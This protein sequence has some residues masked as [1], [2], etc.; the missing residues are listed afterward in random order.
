MATCRELEIVREWKTVGMKIELWMT[1]ENL[2][3]EWVICGNGFCEKMA[4]KLGICG[5]H[6]EFWE[7]R[8]F[9]G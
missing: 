8:S 4:G 2:E 3:S 1:T 9:G 6:V 7:S 5:R